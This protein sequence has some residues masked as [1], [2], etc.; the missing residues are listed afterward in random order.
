[1]K[2]KTS[3]LSTAIGLALS[4]QAGAAPSSADHLPAL[5]TR[6]NVKYLSG[7]IG[8]T[9]VSAIKHVAKYYPLELEFVVKAKPKDEYTAGVNVTIKDEYHKTVLNATT[10]GPFLLAKLPAGKYT[11]SAERNQEVKTRTITIAAKD[12]LRAVFEWQA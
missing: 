9:E 11:V 2:T 1:M 10:D 7:G 3:I 5:Q 12:H 6:G 4:L 8:E